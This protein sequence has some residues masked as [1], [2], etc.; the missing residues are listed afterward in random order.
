MPAPAQ[1]ASQ[2][3]A[4]NNSAAARPAVAAT[5]TPRVVPPTQQPADAK[6]DPV[7]PK[8]VSSQKTAPRLSAAPVAQQAPPVAAAPKADS[9]N[10]QTLF[11]NWPEEIPRNG[12]V[13]NTLNE[14]MP[15]KGFMLAGEMVLLERSNPDQ[16]GARYIVMKYESME[17]VKIVHPLNTAAFLPI[18]FKGKLTN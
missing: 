15:F 11:E 8:G 6:P 10:W 4:T 17:L 14:P 13:V 16:L 2:L 5:V 3:P 1:A 12:I 9:M 18:G 7:V